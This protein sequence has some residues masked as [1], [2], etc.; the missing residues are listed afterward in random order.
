MKKQ[1]WHFSVPG[2]SGPWAL[3]NLQTTYPWNVLLTRL[4]K[5]VTCQKCLKLR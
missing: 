5:E 1:K 3:C 4:W 2:G